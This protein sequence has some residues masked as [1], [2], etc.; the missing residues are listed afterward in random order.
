MNIPHMGGEAPK[1]FQ[2]WKEVGEA[3]VQRVFGQ[4]KPPRA[5]ISGRMWNPSTIW[6]KMVQEI[7]TFCHVFIRKRMGGFLSC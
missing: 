4:K 5:G 3:V 7:C 6:F 1:N 2:R